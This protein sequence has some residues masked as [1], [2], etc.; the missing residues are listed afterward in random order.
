MQI[1][2]SPITPDTESL[3]QMHGG[4][5]SL[6]GQHG[7]YVVMRTDVYE[8][9]LG[10]EADEEAETLASVR[11]GVADVQTGRTHDVEAVFKN[12]ISRHEA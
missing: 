4:P 5:L 1:P 11:R 6:E 2:T 7:K 10:L 12:L 3:L 9:M 8:A